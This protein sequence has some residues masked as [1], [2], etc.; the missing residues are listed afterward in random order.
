V[1]PAYLVGIVG[2][3]VGATRVLFTQS[4]TWLRIARPIIDALT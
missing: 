1:H 4:E 3:F 2:L